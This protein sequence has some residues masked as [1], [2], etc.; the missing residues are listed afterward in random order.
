MEFEDIMGQLKEIMDSQE[1][2]Q[3]LHRGEKWQYSWDNDRIHEGADVEKVGITA[4]DRYPL[5]AL[6]SDMHKV[7]ENVHAWLQQQMELYLEEQ[8]DDALDVDACKAH[9]QSL[10]M[11]HYKLQSI[12]ANVDSLRDTYE[13][14]VLAGGGY[15]AARHR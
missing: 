4:E 1:K 2:S 15:I 7:I 5:P 11:D 14:I 3:H 8:G 13:A 6:S 9:L 10:F 12:Q